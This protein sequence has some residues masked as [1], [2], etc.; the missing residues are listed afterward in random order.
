[1]YFNPT[2]RWGP[3]L[4]FFGLGPWAIIHDTFISQILTLMTLFERSLFQLSENH[5]WIH[6]IQVR[7]LLNFDIS[8]FHALSSFIRP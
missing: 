1:M 6:G 2:F 7:P 5:Y 8:L 4:A 3:N